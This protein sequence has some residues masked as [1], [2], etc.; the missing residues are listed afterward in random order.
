LTPAANGGRWTNKH[1]DGHVATVEEVTW[2]AEDGIRYLLPE[3]VLVFKA[4]LRRP[5]DE[6][7]FEA[8][9]PI[10]TAER[11]EWMRNAVTRVA[12]DHPWLERF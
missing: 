7:D 10:L 8:T 6:P 9:L 12:P 11:R 4:R 2:V 5:K 1:L 3:I